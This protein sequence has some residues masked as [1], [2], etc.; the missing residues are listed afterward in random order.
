MLTLEEKS[1]DSF[2]IHEIF[3]IYTGGDLIICKINSGI[4]PVIS[5]TAMN[6]GV[7]CWTEEIQKRKLFSYKTTISLA[8]RG[9]FYAFV[10][11]IDFYIG[12]RV[13]ALEFLNLVPRNAMF[14]LAEQ[15]NQQAIKFCYGNNACDNLDSM[16]IILPVNNNNE[17]DYHYMDKYMSSTKENLKSEYIKY[18]EDQYNSLD[19][20]EIEP[21]DSKNWKEFYITKLFPE[22][23]RG[24]R[25][26]KNNQKLGDIPYVS[27]TAFNNGVDNYIIYNQKEMRMYKKCLSLANSG[28]V[29]STFYEPFEFIAS[30]HVTHLQ[31]DNYN[32]YIYL[33]IAAIITRLSEKYNFNREINDKRVAREKIILPVADNG[34]PDF[35]YIERYVKYTI[36][37]QYNI[38]LNFIKK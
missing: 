36:K 11:N 22:I 2:K 33:F 17:P 21:L 26:T 7:S 32:K 16:R 15:I 20:N 30:D 1:W 19:V 25:L 6:N 5:H 35:D 8:D 14:F 37:Q 31:N 28:S 13:K 38:Y 4:I 3:K 9:N 29:G 12:T 23:K 24:K 18:A 34:D 27:S 10:Q